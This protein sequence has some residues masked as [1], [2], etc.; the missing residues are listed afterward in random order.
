MMKILRKVRGELITQEVDV[1]STSAFAK[2]I[3]TPNLVQATFAT[4][5]TAAEYS[6]LLDSFKRL[7]RPF[8]V[9]V[10]TTNLEIK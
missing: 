5:T 7:V 10:V 6:K 4:V 2:A 9:C 8:A 3:T 1:K